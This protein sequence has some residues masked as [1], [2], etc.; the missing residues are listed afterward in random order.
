ML[1]SLGFDTIVIHTNRFYSDVNKTIETFYSFGIKN[2]LFIFDYDPLYD[3]T[4]ILKSKIKEFKNI[5]KSQ[6]PHRVKIKTALNLNISPGVAFND[7]IDQI[8]I[9]KKSKALFTSL[10]LFTDINYDPISLDINHLLYKKSSFLVFTDFEEI[11]ESSSVEFCSKFI[12]NSKIGICTDLNY[13]LNP[14]KKILFNKIITAN[15]PILPSISRDFGNYAGILNSSEFIIKQYGKKA[16][17]SLCSQ[18]NRA[19]TKIFI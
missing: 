16:Y 1:T 8:Y 3:S 11:V 13:L 18:I 19:S 2:F 6:S 7:S 10:P 17:Y 14:E 4:A 9:S 5:H 15:C 12:N